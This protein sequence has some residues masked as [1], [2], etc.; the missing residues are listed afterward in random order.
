MAFPMYMCLKLTT[1][2]L[3]HDSYPP[4]PT[5]TYTC[6]VKITPGVCG[7]AINNFEVLK[8]IATIVNDIQH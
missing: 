7:G 3:Y 2:E 1:R 4:H 5:S 6:E 8:I